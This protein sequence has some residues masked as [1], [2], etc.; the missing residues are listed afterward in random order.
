MWQPTQ[1]GS[2]CLMAPDGLTILSISSMNT[3]PSCSATR[4][5]SS[6][7]RVQIHVGNS[8]HM[9]QPPL[10][11]MARHD[12]ARDANAT[13]CIAFEYGAHRITPD[14]TTMQDMVR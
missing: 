14:H 5:C 12:K 1:Q 13:L 2:P 7:Q 4:T 10:G 11:S 3:M 9:V 8:R 6:T